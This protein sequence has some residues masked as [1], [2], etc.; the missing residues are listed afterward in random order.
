MYAQGPVIDYVAI[1]FV[2]HLL[3]Q[4]IRILP[5]CIQIPEN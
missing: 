5:F 2:V 4:V 1:V 3:N